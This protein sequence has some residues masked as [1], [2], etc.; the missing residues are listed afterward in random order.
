MLLAIL[1]A[2]RRAGA[3]PGTGGPAIDFLIICQGS[4]AA[5]ISSVVGSKTLPIRSLC[6]PPSAL[7]GCERHFAAGFSLVSCGSFSRR[8]LCC[9]SF[10]CGVYT[11][12]RKRRLKRCIVLLFAAASH[13]SLGVFAFALCVRPVVLRE[14]EIPYRS[15]FRIYL[16]SVSVLPPPWL[17]FPRL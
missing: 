2:P 11:H 16:R 7:L 15:S 4:A 1:A 3:D 5:V 14:G 9:V 13:P 6:R 12:L 17:A 10:Y 8:V